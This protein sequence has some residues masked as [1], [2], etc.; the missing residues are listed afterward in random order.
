MN[1]NIYQLL[2][3]IETY[4]NKVNQLNDY[5]LNQDQTFLIVKKL[6]NKLLVISGELKII[7]LYFNINNTNYNFEE[8]LISLLELD[9]LNIIIKIDKIIKEILN[10]KSFSHFEATGL[11]QYLKH[12]KNEAHILKNIFKN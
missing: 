3:S 8:T 10:I 2:K 5:L 12:I 9:I 4:D 1:I 11:L 7:G 6:Q